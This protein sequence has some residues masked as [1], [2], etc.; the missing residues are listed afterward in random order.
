MLGKAHKT[1]LIGLVAG[2][3]LYAIAGF[4]VAPR[5][6]KLWIESPNVSG[7]TC[8][9]RVQQVYVNPFTMFLSLKDVTLFEKENKMQVSAIRAET[10]VW[11]VG[12]LRSE[13]P[14]HDV[15]IQ[16]LVVRDADSDRTLLAVPR[17][18]ARSVT[19]GAGGTFIGAAFAGLERPEATVA[20]DATGLLRWPAWLSVPGDE[21]TAA[22]ISLAGVEVFDGTLQIKDD[23]VTPGVELELRDITAAAL[24]KP[25]RGAAPTEINIE[26]RIGAAGTV[27]LDARLG[28]AAGQHP[29]WFTLTTRN[30]ELPPLSPYFR[31]AFGRD[32]MAGVGAA[33][34]QQERHDG[35]LRF[36][37]HVSIV[38][39]ILGDPTRDTG[40]DEPPLDVAL[41]LATDAEDRTELVVQGS[42]NDS[43]AI[44]IVSVFA[45]SLAAHL[46]NLDARAFGVL[47]ALVGNPDAVLDEIAFLPGSAEMAPAATDTLALLA[48]A[49]RERPLVG[50][51]V[52]PTYDPEADRDAM[53]AEQIRLHIALA[54]SKG[55]RERGDTRDPDFDDPRVRDVL[56]EFADTR[57]PAAR[58][59][60]IRGNTSDE[61][62]MYRDI[63]LALVDNE[64]ISETVLRRLARFR[65]RSVIDALERAGI[66]RQRFRIDDA[67]DTS[68]TDARTVTLKVEVEADV[69]D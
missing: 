29:D 69:A 2:V 10:R 31:R 23:A 45:D 27:S 5:A 6:I 13:R 65:A 14:G 47:A 53:A 24:R 1:W 64:R 48:L 25:G 11:T 66:D 19:V 26:A 49:L 4:L 7:P 44:T 15:A 60:A 34:L 62:R 68:T 33:T 57:L 52:R 16:G 41:A 51:R 8:R 56:D 54:T 18:F 3:A 37:N 67:L 59:R 30:L 21:R 42:T 55:T 12:M 40:G 46:D 9:L 20:R 28:Q 32:I 63:Y 22:C 17:V 39:L 35:T 58:R 38:G 36:D 61:T 50:L 43:S